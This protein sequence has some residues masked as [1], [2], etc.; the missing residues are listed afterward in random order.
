MRTS[1]RRGDAP[2]VRPALGGT[3]MDAETLPTLTVRLLGRLEV[4]AC[5]TPVRLGGRHA[6]ALAAL[7]ALRP[8]PRLRD[9]I[10]ADLWP[11]FGGPSASS[12]RQALWLLRN[13][14]TTAGV[15]PD[16]VLDVGPDTLGLR[17]ETRLDVDATRFEAM[18]ADGPSSSSLALDLYRGDLAECLGHEC[19]AADRERMSD[20]YEDALAA[21][22]EQRLAA[23]DIAGA[24][25]AATTLLARDPLREEAHGVLIAVYGVSG[26]RSQVVRQYRRLADILRT[27][28]AVRPLP[29]TQE[30]YREALARSEERSA[31]RA[32]ES[33]EFVRPVLRRVLAPAG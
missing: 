31:D 18:V 4:E 29:E 6:Q 23:G 28:L 26:S 21:A 8:R 2:G 13:A 14:L 25:S 5:G 7:L 19:F 9:A 33:R 32:R 10:A 17:R 24:R 27:E 22:A 15:D 16:A 20:L 3:I 11:D 12:L 30:L 1:G